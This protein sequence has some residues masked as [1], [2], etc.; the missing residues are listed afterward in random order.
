[1]AAATVETQP[2]R[3]RKGYSLFHLNSI[4]RASGTP[5]Q[6]GLPISTSASYRT[7]EY[8]DMRSLNFGGAIQIN[9]ETLKNTVRNNPVLVDASRAVTIVV[10]RISVNPAINESSQR[11]SRDLPM[12]DSSPFAESI[13]IARRDFIDASREA[14]K[15]Q[16]NEL[17]SSKITSES[18]IKFTE[19]RLDG[20]SDRS[21]TNDDDLKGL[22]AAYDG[23]CRT[24]CRRPGLFGIKRFLKS[25]QG[26][27][28]YPISDT[29]S[30]AFEFVRMLIGDDLNEEEYAKF[31]DDE[32]ELAT[33][34]ARV[35]RHAMSRPQDNTS[36]QFVA[37][38]GVSARTGRT[39]S[40]L[41]NTSQSSRSRG[42]QRSAEADSLPVSNEPSMQPSTMTLPISTPRQSLG[43]A[44]YPRQ[45]MHP[46]TATCLYCERVEF[47]VRRREITIEML[48]DR[49]EDSLAN[50]DTYA[51]H[52]R[53]STLKPFWSLMS[54]RI[55]SEM[56][57]QIG[58][59]Y[60]EG[61]ILAE[62][63]EDIDDCS[64]ALYWAYEKRLK[65]EQALENGHTIKAR[66]YR[67]F[68]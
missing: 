37:P 58:N 7:P 45:N 21:Q 17:Q 67:W 48:L 57:K 18:H 65:V 34:A 2:V 66:F 11:R 33:H 53:Y 20:F 61:Y 3:P 13:A 55:L 38:T 51:Q 60:S 59:L 4:G 41:P 25:M 5:D 30:K 43:K 46:R 22:Q 56:Q 54:D 29:G 19:V 10:D 36:R 26:M 28:Y 39:T 31:A 14:G 8:P 32:T 49:V 64:K 9:H 40:D 1:M 24:Y 42:R 50:N 44:P 62:S 47:P 23:Y 68:C 16:R 52:R 27:A 12:I 6:S 63:I 35:L 15:R